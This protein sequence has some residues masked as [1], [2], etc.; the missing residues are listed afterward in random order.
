MRGVFRIFK[1]TRPS[2]FPRHSALPFS[3]LGFIPIFLIITLA[4][5][6]EILR[7]PWSFCLSRIHRIFEETQYWLSQLCLLEAFCLSS[8]SIPHFLHDLNCSPLKSV[9]WVYTW[10]SRQ[11]WGLQNPP[12]YLCP[13]GPPCGIPGQSGTPFHP[14]HSHQTS[15]LS[16]WIL[17][18][19]QIGRF[20]IFLDHVSN[21]P[22]LD[23]SVSH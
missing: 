2:I 8:E 14:P 7:S 3:S 5:C 18:L 16:P 12:S 11:S 15:L 13:M 23:L 9:Q 22:E 19:P 6:W 20:L 1:G 17:H 4:L 10:P 21:L